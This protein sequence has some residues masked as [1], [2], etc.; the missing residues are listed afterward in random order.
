MSLL[1]FFYKRAHYLTTSKPAQFSVCRFFSGLGGSAGIAI[2][3][4]FV[5]DIWD[6]EARPK[7]SGIVML[8]P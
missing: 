8:G 7:A 2:I 4:G 5:A 3:G 1:Q 6:L